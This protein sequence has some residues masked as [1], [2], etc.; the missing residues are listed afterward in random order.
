MCLF[1]LFVFINVENINKLIWEFRVVLLRV[2]FY[3]VYLIKVILR[4]VGDRNF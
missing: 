3:R 2:S 4:I 1:F